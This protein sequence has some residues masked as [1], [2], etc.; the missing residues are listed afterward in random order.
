[1]KMWAG[2][3]KIEGEDSM[4]LRVQRP[5]SYAGCAKITAS[6]LNAASEISLSF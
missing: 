6:R 1:M 4:G 5:H 2:R 3:R